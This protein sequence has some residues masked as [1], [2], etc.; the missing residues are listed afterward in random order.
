MY[1]AKQPSRSEFIDIR[2]LRYH[3]RIWGR[4]DAPQLFLCHGWMDTSASFQF[5]VDALQ[6]D[7]QVIAPDWRGFGLTEKVKSDTYYF[8]DYFAD[9]ELILDH[10]QRDEQPINL[11]GHSMGGNVVSIYAGIRPER[12]RRLVNIEGFGLLPH[13]AAEAPEHFAGWIDRLKKGYKLKPY[14]SFEALAERLKAKNSGLD[15]GQAL[16]LAHHWGYDTGE[17]IRLHA[18]PYHKN[19]NP[20]LYRVKESIACWQK[21]TAPMLAI[22]GKSSEFNQWMPVETVKE[23]LAVFPNSSSEWFDDAGHMIHFDQP[24]RLANSIERFLLN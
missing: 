2:H 24:E 12:I 3:V 17:E 15:D 11:V 22:I 6:Q 7:W 13:K 9:L 16:F 18:D 5:M 20:V 8:P 4:D 23:R 14:A 19:R 10:Y 21:V 1:Q